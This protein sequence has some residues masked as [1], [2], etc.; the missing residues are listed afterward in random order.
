MEKWILVANC[1]TVGLANSMELLCPDIEIEPVDIGQFN[2][3]IDH[4]NERFGDYDR[5]LASRESQ[6]QPGAD[7]T[8]ARRLTRVPHLN[9]AGYHPDLAYV[10][11]GDAL[12]EGPLGHYQSSIA[13][14]AYR[15]GLDVEQAVSLYNG[16]FYEACGYFDYWADQR[17]QLVALYTRTFKIDIAPAVRRWAREGA[18]MY[19]SNHPRIR[20][21][22]DV[23]RLFLKRERCRVEDAGILPHDNL[24]ASSCFPVYPEIGEALGVSGSYLFKLVGRYRQIGLRQFVTESYAVFDRHGAEALAP[25]ANSV[26][27]HARVAAQL[28]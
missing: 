24:V 28:Q 14:A 6:L 23:A 17:D 18:F 13:L 19:S 9:F 4:Y 21:L 7:F 25:H 5:V 10:T 16:R 26:D 22:F 12:I 8:R 3:H 20:A 1:Q 2:Q 15:C 11:A 27:M